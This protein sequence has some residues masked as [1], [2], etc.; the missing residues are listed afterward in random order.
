MIRYPDELRKAN[1]E[2]EVIAQF[3]VDADGHCLDGSFKV[4][5]SNNPLFDDAVRK[6]L[7]NMRFTP[8]LVNGKAVRQMLEQPFIFSLSKQ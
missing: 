4:V 1:V 7:P 3:V 5:K 2:G 6:A 8:A